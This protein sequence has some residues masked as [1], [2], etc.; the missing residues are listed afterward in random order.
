LS[1]WKTRRISNSRLAHDEL[2]GPFRLRLINEFASPRI[3]STKM[4]TTTITLSPTLTT[5]TGVTPATV[6]DR[7]SSEA[8][9]QLFGRIVENGSSYSSAIATGMMFDSSTFITSTQVKILEIY[10]FFSK[11]V[12]NVD[13]FGIKIKA[14]S[15]ILC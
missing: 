9:D 3:T 11:K 8:V 13:R 7:V 2:V 4:T 15:R 10:I 14:Q 12:H 5:T 6:I 1:N